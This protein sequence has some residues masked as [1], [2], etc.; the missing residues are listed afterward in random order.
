MSEEGSVQMSTSESKSVSIPDIE[1]QY[2]ETHRE[3]ERL[4]AEQGLVISGG[5]SHASRIFSPFPLFVSKVA[6]AHKWDI[7]GHEYV[8]Y[9]MGH[10]ANLLGHCY[11]KIDAAIVAQVGSGL[12]AGG[13]TPLGLEWA[14]LVCGMV[15]SAETV[16][17][18]AS[19]G[20]ATLLAIRLARAFT[21]RQK[22]VKL[23]YN[24]HGW[25]DAVATGIFPPFD[26]AWSAGIPRAS[27]DDTI[28]L[29]YNDSSALEEYFSTAEDV[30]G[31]ILEP[32][33]AFNDTIPVDPEFLRRVR[34]LTTA[35]SVVLIFDEVIT[36]FRYAPG[37]AQEFFGVVPDVTCLGKIVAGGLPGGAVAGKRE[38]MDLLAPPGPGESTRPY[39]PHYGTWNAAPITAAAGIAMLT[40][41]RDGVLI[42]ET[43]HRADELRLGLNSV[44]RSRGVAG[45]A[46]GR[47][48]LWK[49]MLGEP[50]RLL[51]GDYSTAQ[52]DGQVLFRGLGQLTGTLRKAMLHEG[53]DIM[54]G[55]GFMSAAHST[56]D[57]DRTV[58][59]LD[60]ALDRLQRSSL[61]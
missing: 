57:V 61:L 1:R 7:D 46:Y 33:G 20:E 25:H 37:G 17:F 28:L 54:G 21:G 39:V 26:R 16:R 18:C 40:E 6:G 14:R 12:H 36:G 35:R 56:A 38:V 34:E 42:N 15:P 8:D 9:W 59:S 53:V 31:V 55:G 5:F 27:A 47:S 29:P 58:S 23:E 45:V 43:T 52:G 51:D 50:P 24:F 60:R 49:M 30:A 19:G 3:S 13:E 44:F 10:G 48:S 2:C 4:F 11:P 22:L 32:A 41:L